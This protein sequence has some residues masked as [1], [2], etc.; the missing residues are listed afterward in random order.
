[1]SNEPVV[2]VGG[3]NSAGQAAVHLARYA[4]EVTLVVRGASLASSMSDYLIQQIAAVPNITIRYHC[5]VVEAFG[6]RQL[7]RVALRDSSTGQQRLLSCHGLFVLIGGSPRTD[8]LPVT[9]RRDEWGSILTGQDAGTDP[10]AT[11]AS[12]L[13]GLYAVGDV[14][15]GAAKRVAGAVGDG[16]L[17]IR[18]VHQYIETIRAG[19]HPVGVGL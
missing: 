19:R 2:V 6:E 12:S 11:N 4:R 15:R 3:G 8:W 1:M 16:A 7:Q 18:Q 17:A 14:R 5:E 13:A 10:L 9:V